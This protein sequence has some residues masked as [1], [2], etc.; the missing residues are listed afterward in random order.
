[1]TPTPSET[2]WPTSDYMVNPHL[3]RDILAAV[4]FL[5]AEDIP[6]H[7][8]ERLNAP[9]DRTLAALND[10]VGIRQEGPARS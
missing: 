6:E 4:A 7:V 1:M 10:L 5:F 9:G 2:V 8:Y 3:V